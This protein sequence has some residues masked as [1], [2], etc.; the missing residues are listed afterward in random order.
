MFALARIRKRTPLGAE[1]DL[2]VADDELVSRRLSVACPLDSPGV[3][4]REIGGIVEDGAERDVDLV[5]RAADLKQAVGSRRAVCFSE[6]TSSS[7]QRN[8]DARLR[9]RSRA[10]SRGSAR[11]RD[12]PAGTPF[13]GS[14]TTRNPLPSGGSGSVTSLQS[15]SSGSPSPS[16]RRV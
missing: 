1:L 6:V 12:L 16:N 7:V 10:S 15:F 11:P 3:L 2:T 8:L 4:R 13:W 14:K 9:P 5:C